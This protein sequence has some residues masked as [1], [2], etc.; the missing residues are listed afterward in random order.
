METYQWNHHHPNKDFQLHYP[1]KR[2]QQAI[3][4]DSRDQ[5]QDLDLVFA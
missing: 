1:M 4:M 5:E 2:E 3:E